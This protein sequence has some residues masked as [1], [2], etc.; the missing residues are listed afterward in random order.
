MPTPHP[1]RNIVKVVP[2]Q[3]GDE[4]TLPTH[5]GQGFIRRS[6]EAAGLFFEPEGGEGGFFITRDVIEKALGLDQVV[7]FVREVA[8]DL[9]CVPPEDGSEYCNRADDCMRCGARQVLGEL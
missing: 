4:L 5:T 3:Q 9:S 8:S 2:V 1:D 6:A 7:A